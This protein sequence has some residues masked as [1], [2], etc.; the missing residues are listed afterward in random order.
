MIQDELIYQI[1][2]D[3]GFEPTHD[4][5]NALQTFAQFMTDRRDN[6]VM[7]LRGSAGT[8][9]TSFAG[10]I[11]RAVT[12]LRIKVSLLAPTGRAA[13]V[14]SLNAGLIAST[15]H[16]KIYREKTFNGTDGQ[17]QLNNNMFRNMLFMVDEASMISTSQN[18]TMFGS[19][20]LL[21]DLIQYI[22]NSG[23]NC[24]LLL[25]GDK[26]QLPPVG[27]QESPALRF[28][29][30]QG[31]GLHVYEC[32]LNEVLRQS[33]HSGILWNA[34]TIRQMISRNT[35]TQLPKIR[36]EGFADISIVSGDE[37]IESIASSYATVGTD[38]TMVITRSNKR[39]NI[40]NQ[41]IRNTILGCEDELTT[42][43]LVMVVKN[44]Y[45][46]KDRSTDLSFIANGDHAVVRRVR[47]I[48][49]LYGFR[50]A[51]VSLEFPDYNKT[52]L[53]T[54]V[55]LDTLVAEAP[56]LTQEQN[57]KL[58]QSVMEDYT[59]IPRKADRIKQLRE[60]QYF[61]AM[62]IKFGYAVTCH[63]AQGGQWAHIYLDQG[64][65]TDEML[66]TDYIHWLYTAFTRA[67]E[68]LYL[69]N[70]NKKQ[71]AE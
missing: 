57:T 66:T 56:A 70:W 23:D 18:N 62:Q 29:V 64:Y 36:L 5:R 14:F 47:N 12:R 35:A 28:D 38:E 32:D 8:G 21:D 13:K 52:E 60:D 24:R 16:R 25:I 45:L 10:A 4:Q 69:V 19:G 50:F 58:F 22:Y 43:D 40:F 7:I 68:H 44:K 53:D 34:T 33:Q 26:A 37:L 71:I 9:K 63:K 51:D 41:G 46:E 59:D 6:A 49:E 55:V 17:F 42:G 31:Y 3:F 67:T 15:I 54:V 2:Q 30:L 65:M 11:V 27:E 1:L 48:R 39:A 61:N 20:C